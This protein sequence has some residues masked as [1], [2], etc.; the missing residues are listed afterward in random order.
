[1]SSFKNAIK[2]FSTLAVIL[3]SANANSA[4]VNFDVYAK[5]NSV[6]G[7]VGLNTGLNFSVGDSIT[8]SVNQNDYWS[9]NPS[10][11]LF[12]S[13]AN[14][15]VGNVFATG[16]DESGKAAGV[17]IGRE[18]PR[19]WSYNG[20]TTT[21]GTLVGEIN[22]N[23]FVLGTDINVMAPDTGLLS[24]YYWDD[25]AAD[26]AGHVTVSLDNNISNVPVPAAVWLFGSGL[27]G[28]IGANRKK[29]KQSTIS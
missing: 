19:A 20:L 12:W 8:G 23:Y 27:V 21:F 2:F 13:N 9:A 15:L 26:N 6:L 11:G 14:G 29:T 18:Y 24:L 22:N 3:L 4:I 16:V 28:L 25:V 10:R 7:G 17:R 5:E 1:M